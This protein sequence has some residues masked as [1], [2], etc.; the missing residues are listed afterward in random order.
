MRSRPTVCAI[1]KCSSYTARPTKLSGFSLGDRRASNFRGS[2]LNSRIASSE[3]DTRSRRRVSASCRR[4]CRRRSI[5]GSASRL[6]PRRRRRQRSPQTPIRCK[7]AK[8]RRSALGALCIGH[9][10]RAPASRAANTYSARVLAQLLQRGRAAF[11]TVHQEPSSMFGAMG[12]E[13]TL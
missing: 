2:R 5:P 1:R 8:Y 11:A 3:W 13:F 6:G 12:K 4:G 10:N 9:G 7:T